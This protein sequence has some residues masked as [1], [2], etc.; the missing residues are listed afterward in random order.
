V[1]FTLRQ[2][3]YAVAVADLLSFRRAAERCAVSQPALSAQLARLEETLGV[4]LFERN[5][6]RV[7]PTSSGRALVERARRLLRDGGD[8]V[9]AA[10][11]ASDPLAGT[12]RIGIIPT[13]APY[14]LPRSAPRLRRRFPRLTVAWVEEKTAT[15][16]RMLEEGGLDAALL[17]LEAPLGD[18]EHEVVGKDPFVLVAAPS[19][20]LGASDR[21]AAVEDLEGASVLLLED[22]HC[23]RD[24]ALAF[25]ERAEAREG[26]FRATS[27]ATLA[28]MVA[29]GLGVTLL[30][31]LAVPTEASRARLRTRRLARPEPF[32]TI[33]LA[34]R[35]RSPLA[36][37]LRQVA[38]ALREA[39]PR[40]D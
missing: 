38:G 39:Y 8:L 19:D 4:R 32:R 31:Q 11:Q 15:L 16:V 23:L 35:R 37:A 10:R 40:P 13:V 27:L 28:Q 18:V 22:G 36:E 21:P 2:L 33:A 12:L 14:L 20:P 5:R 7:L 1:P 29:S 34:W 25:C 17:A 26:E 24:Q 30:P 3:E 9:E 6:R